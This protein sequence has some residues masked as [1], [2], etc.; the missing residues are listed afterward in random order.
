MFYKTN[1]NHN[2]RY[3]PFKACIVP[4]PIGWITT[5]SNNGVVNLAPFSYFNAVSDAPPV[6]MFSSSVKKD[7]DDKDTV[8]NIEQNGEFVFNIATY[9]LH[10]QMLQSSEPL[11]YGVSEVE[12]YGIAT[13]PSKLVKPPRIALS[14]INLECRHIKTVTLDVGGVNPG[15]KVIF[16]HVI[17]C[18]IDDAVLVDGKVD[19]KK[20]RPIARLGYNEYSVVDNIYN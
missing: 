10:D 8:K 11:P 20:V 18:H 2:L 7:G 3:N 6:I 14:P 15:V 17:G 4:R 9:D 1:E 12:E 5:I 13:V 19:L 16:G